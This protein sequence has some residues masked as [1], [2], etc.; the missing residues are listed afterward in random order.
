MSEEPPQ[1]PYNE[2]IFSINTA[3]LTNTEKNKKNLSSKIY[4]FLYSKCSDVEKINAF[5]FVCFK[6]PED[7]LTN[8]EIKIFQ[9]NSIQTINESVLIIELQLLQGSR[10]WIARFF[11]KFFHYLSVNFDVVGSKSEINLVN[12][13]TKSN[14]LDSEK[15]AQTSN[16]DWVTDSELSNKYFDILI[17][18]IQCKFADTRQNGWLLLAKHIKLKISQKQSD[19]PKKNI[20]KICLEALQQKNLPDTVRLI[21]LVLIRIQKSTKIFDNLIV[22][23]IPLL[24]IWAKGPTPEIRAL[25]IRNLIF[26]YQNGKK[27]NEE[28]SIVPEILKNCT[29]H[30]PHCRSSFLAKQ[31][32]NQ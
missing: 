21:L 32:F 31:F 5:E 28:V 23:T 25:S 12:Y 14:I 26:L 7:E 16:C 10:E 15:W 19:I 22:Q 6:Y 30:R 13:E 20:V 17:N 1:V 9:S 11:R 24:K 27:S 3:Y 18:Q 29:T 4:Q 2:E 8:F